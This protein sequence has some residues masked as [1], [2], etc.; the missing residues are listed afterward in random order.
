MGDK[1]DGDGRPAAVTRHA[2]VSHRAW[3]G[4]ARVGAIVALV[5]LVLAACG[6]S[7]SKSS[8]TTTAGSTSAASS[9]GQSTT[10]TAAPKKGGTLTIIKSSEQPAG[11]D[12]ANML[13]VPSN[14]PT[15]VN[16]AVYDCLFYEDASL[17]LVPRL[18]T[19]MTTSD[20]GTTWT[21]KLRPD[22]KFS[23]GTPFDATAVQ[24]NWKRMADPATKALTASVA[25]EI[26]SMNVVDPT[27]LQATLKAPDLFFDHRI[28]E[29]LAWIASPTALQSEGANYG[30]HPVG[31]GPFLMTNW[32]V[33]SQYTFARNPNY[34]EPG[35]PYLDQ[36]ILKVIT[37]PA[38]AYPTFKAGGA[39]AVQMFDPQFVGQAETDGYNL[40]L[41]IATG[42]GWGISLNNSKP[43]FD[44]PL[45]RQ[46]VNQAVNRAQ[47]NQ[48]RRNGDP[49]FAI[50]SLNTKDSP[51]YNPAIA[52]PQGDQAAAQKLVDQYVAQTGHPL[53][54]TLNSFNVGYI[55]QD[56]QLLQ[57]QFS[58]LKNV[59]AKLN[60]EAVPQGIKD[61]TVGNYEAS[62]LPV[63]WSVPAIDM[64]SWFLTGS[65]LN[66]ARYSSP[67]VDALIKQ[68]VS[69]TD[70]SAQ[71][72]LV[73]QI[74]QTVLNDSPYVWFAQQVSA[75]A[76]D[77]TVQNAQV[78]FD[79]QI[80]LDSVWSSAS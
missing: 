35:K 25:Q 52:P 73:D 74:S 17:K 41:G 63:R 65:S 44:N 24:F 45:A 58:Q 5:G 26:Q 57:A 66:Y 34:W 30:T 75:L 2:G 70:V 77:K 79:Q 20:N 80:L 55:S 36:L 71:K 22:V 21:L 6:S 9:A 59:E 48:A 67:Q 76:I 7:S 53:S 10:S 40:T 12:P 49:I 11:W 27:T 16:F 23:D 8:G 33:N 13:P 3:T 68:L 72:P 69:T 29:N 47:F 61:Y 14:T 78:F 18:G 42:G 60:I 39:N 1:M 4:G 62:T 15:L 54:F 37:D 38:T 43:P 64:V 56:A 46:I 31:A 32:V 51:F 19:A 28:T 50:T